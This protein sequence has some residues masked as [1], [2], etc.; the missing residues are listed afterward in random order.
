M[1][2]VDYAAN[3]H[4]QVSDFVLVLSYT[5]GCEQHLMTSG[6]LQ[7]AQIVGCSHKCSTRTFS[8][9]QS[10]DSVLSRT[11]PEVSPLSHTRSASLSLSLLRLLRDDDDDDDASDRYTLLGAQTRRGRTAA[12]VL[13]S[14]WGK[15]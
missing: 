1:C 4:S 6:S 9:R 11:R 8:R 15:P 2:L 10:R 13:I 3:S 5:V 14:W 12:H 7:S